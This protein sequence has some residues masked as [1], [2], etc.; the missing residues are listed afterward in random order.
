MAKVKLIGSSALALALSSLSGCQ[1][2]QLHSEVTVS[3]HVVNDNVDV[4]ALVREQMD[5]YLGYQGREYF[6][7]QILVA[8]ESGTRDRFKGKD[9]DTYA[10]WKIHV[11]PIQW[12]QAEL[13]LAMEEGVEVYQELE[14]VDVPY[15]S[16]TTMNLRSKPTREGKELSQI[17]KGEVFNV[18]A[19]A[20]DLPWFVVEQKGVIKGYMHKDYARSNAGERDILSTPA[21]PLLDTLSAAISPSIKSD[22]PRYD[23]VG[24]YTCRMLNYELSKDGDFTTGSL[25]AC[26]KQRKVW[27][28]DSSLQSDQS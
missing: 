10:W 15:L 14:F 5:M 17:H 9:P 8:L 24:R 2:F 23:L 11:Q 16:K 13:T 21:N 7:N 1:L 6:L 3:S 18:L 28:I 25:R 27:Y 19:I 22:Q 4:I 20:T 12:H 26:R